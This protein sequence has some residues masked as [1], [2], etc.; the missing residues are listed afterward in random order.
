MPMTISDESFEGPFAINVAVIDANRAAVYVIICTHPTGKHYVI[1]VGES[2]EVGERLQDHPR[3]NCWLAQCKFA[4]SVY[5][6][7]LPS[8]EGF[9]EDDR[10]RLETKIRQQYSPPCGAR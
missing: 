10:R 9:T 1:D 2:G 7:Y 8:S 5:L 4:L 6:R 3:L